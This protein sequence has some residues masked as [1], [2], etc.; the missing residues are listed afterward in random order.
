MMKSLDEKNGEEPAGNGAG[1]DPL[2]ELARLS[3]SA[4]LAAAIAL[5][6][7]SHE[8]M[9]NAGAELGALALSQDEA[10]R[11]SEA[12]I[13]ALGALSGQTAMAE[14]FCARAPKAVRGMSSGLLERLADDRAFDVD[15]AL[16]G[17]ALSAKPS[18]LVKRPALVGRLASAG[19][20]SQESR[21]ALAAAAAWAFAEEQRAQRAW[22]RKD[23]PARAH[24]DEQ[25]AGRFMEVVDNFSPGWS[26]ACWEDF[27]GLDV[28]RDAGLAQ[29]QSLMLGWWPLL[30]SGV[31]PFLSA[32]PVDKLSPSQKSLVLTWAQ[33]FQLDAPAWLLPSVEATRSM[34]R[35]LALATDP[36]QFAPSNENWGSSLMQLLGAA[37]HSPWPTLRPLNASAEALRIMSPPPRS[38]LGDGQEIPALTQ[39]WLAFAEGLA[40]GGA[41]PPHFAIQGFSGSEDSF[42]PADMPLSLAPLF[43]L[44]LEAPVGFFERHSKV[45][46]WL[47]KGADPRE[48]ACLRRLAKAWMPGRKAPVVNLSEA[49]IKKMLASLSMLDLVEIGLASKHAISEPQCKAFRQLRI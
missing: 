12:L 28:E 17:F 41:E 30:P 15:A 48:A 6:E 27:W 46:S 3:P 10:S 9:R 21:L 26:Q 43:A 44:G 11:S 40:E 45:F 7:S 1:V 33:A 32:P 24:P 47:A 14:A 23:N 4:A 34:G 36:G 22:A 38:D 19:H 39:I 25:P 35:Y 8:S 29:S 49:E 37:K 13:F 31:D 20:V 18:I 16:P 5:G 2:S 42:F